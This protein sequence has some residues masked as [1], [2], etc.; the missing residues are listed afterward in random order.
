MDLKN[1]KMKVTF[2]I[3]AKP[4]GGFIARSADPSV[5]SIEAPT[6]EELQEK[7]Q[8]ETLEKLAGELPVL[9]RL[10]ESQL[11][12]GGMVTSKQ[13][14][15]VVIRTTGNDTEVTEL[16]SSEERDEVAKELSGFVKKSFPE[17]SR[18]LAAP[19]DTKTPTM[20]EEGPS[21]LGFR[22]PKQNEVVANT[23]IVPEANY[24]WPFFVLALLILGALMYFASL[25]R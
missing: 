17:L 18:A 7:I 5:P 20:P 9:K 15:T 13:S 12:P 8:T 22:T 4:G 11:K 1:L 10:L 6:R 14:S 25:H 3:E 19:E 21:S 24:W 2:R 23:P 16:S